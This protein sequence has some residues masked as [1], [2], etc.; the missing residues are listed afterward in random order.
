MK[1]SIGIIAHSIPYVTQTISTQPD[2]A[3]AIS[4][5]RLLLSECDL[6]SEDILYFAEWPALKELTCDGPSYAVCVGGGKEAEEFF[7][8]NGKRGII[9]GPVNP[10]LAF[11]I[12]QSI[13]LR[14]NQLEQRLMKSILLK[15]PMQEILNCCSEFF[16]DQAVLFDC[17][18]NIVDNSTNYPPDDNNPFW[19]ELR[20]TKRISDKL[21]QQT[22]KMNP[23]YDPID[24]PCS[25]LI[26][27]GD[28][29]P[30]SLINSFYDSNRRIASLM[31]LDNNKP[32]SS[33]Q[34]KLLDYISEL[35]GPSL[36]DRYST[37]HG[38]VENLRAVFV[39]YLNKVNVDPAFVDRCLG[40][41]SWG[42]R[43]DYRLIL[44]NFPDIARNAET[45][46]RYLHIYEN[47][48]P[49]CLGF[50][51][52]ESLVIVI[53]HDSEEVMASCMPNLERQL[54]L[55][56]AVCGVSLPFNSIRQINSQYINAH[57]A[58]QVGNKNQRVRYTKDIMTNY[59]INKIASDTPLIPLCSREAMR[60]YDYDI[61]NGTKLLLTL[62]TYLRQNKS[63]KT[64]AE[65]LFI[66]RSTLAYRL[67]CIEKLAKIDFDDSNKRLHLLLSCI[68]LRNLGEQK[69]EP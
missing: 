35:I 6:Y 17:T 66:H 49:D 29:S 38:P 23:Q 13:F 19:K 32:V 57:T 55:H 51:Y 53:H 9:L 7:K 33:C 69:I 45:L 64:A 10:S 3:L 46:T 61:E 37:L 41:S 67:S 68:V 39:M 30:R 18:F 54:K 20:E 26:D 44:V 12:I 43:D 25:E 65:E 58:I 63:Q 47:V 36:F 11:G 16:Q 1:L 42:M 8:N 2:R 24:S 34:L 56:N 4:D 62:E 59:L 21:F 28:G 14:Y 22:R 40:L 52:L 31:I 50:K 60:I 27:P 15:E 5:I 48:F